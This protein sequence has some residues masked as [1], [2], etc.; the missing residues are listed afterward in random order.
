M[1][2]PIVMSKR[3]HS[4]LPSVKFIKLASVWEMCCIY[5]IIIVVLPDTKFCHGNF[6]AIICGAFNFQLFQLC[7][8]RFLFS[9]SVTLAGW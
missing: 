8:K 2:L 4:L 7:L 5:P 3:P 6:R 9:V 1:F